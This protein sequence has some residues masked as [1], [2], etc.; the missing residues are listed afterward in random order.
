[1]PTKARNQLLF[2]IL[3]FAWVTGS[4]TETVPVFQSL[5]GRIVSLI[6]APAKT[7]DDL[8][9]R[10]V[11]FRS[12]TEAIDMATSTGRAMWQMIGILAELERSL[13]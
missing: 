2:W 4:V 9:T 3:I 12:L 7:L 11:V 13:I 8:K 6:F 10:G 5:K 1:M